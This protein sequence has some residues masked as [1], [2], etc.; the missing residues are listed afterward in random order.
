MYHYTSDI[1]KFIDQY[2][3]K[4]PDEQANRLQH[5]HKLWDVTLDQ[6]ELEEFKLGEVTKKPYTYFPNPVQADDN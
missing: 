3:E 5:R 1:T 2:L 4:H 6:E